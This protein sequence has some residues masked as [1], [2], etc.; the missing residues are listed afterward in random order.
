MPSHTWMAS[1]VTPN[2]SRVIRAATSRHMTS[3]PVCMWPMVRRKTRL[4]SPCTTFDLSNVSTARA[5]DEC[6][7]LGFMMAPAVECRC[8]TCLKLAATLGQFQHQRVELVGDGR[9]LIRCRFVFVDATDELRLN[10]EPNGTHGEERAAPRLPDGL[11]VLRAAE[12]ADEEVDAKLF[13][14]GLHF[15]RR[16]ERGLRNG[17]AMTPLRR[18]RKSGCNGRAQCCMSQACYS[19]NARSVSGIENV[20]EGENEPEN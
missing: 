16:L 3:S 1:G 15:G 10:A 11:R 9:K 4:T 17:I 18:V 8:S 6:V 2:A 12:C 20:D 7:W 19:S 5:L 14:L 13:A